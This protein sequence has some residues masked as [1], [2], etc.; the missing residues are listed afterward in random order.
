MGYDIQVNRWGKF[1]PRRDTNVLPSGL[2]L[3][4]T[5]TLFGSSHAA[6]FNMAFCDGSVQQLSYS[7]DATTHARLSNCLN[8]LPIDAS[9]I[10]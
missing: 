8:T 6:G 7:I 1:T 3:P 2:S 5:Y 9:Q 4:D 10:R